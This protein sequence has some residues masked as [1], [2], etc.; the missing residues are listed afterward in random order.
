M[1]TKLADKDPNLHQPKPKPP[2]PKQ[3]QEKPGIES[4]L[5]PSPRF[6]A[7]DY[8]SAGS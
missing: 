5:V 2:F 6:Q 4:K 7:E 8:R 1:S 3:H